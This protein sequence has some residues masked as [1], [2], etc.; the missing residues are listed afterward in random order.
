MNLPEVLDRCRQS[1]H[2]PDFSDAIRWKEEHPGSKAVGCFPVYT[3]AEIIHACGM[4]PV[5]IMGAGALGAAIL[6]GWRL[7]KT[8][9]AA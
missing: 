4:L 2:D 6:S 3:P 8:R 7:E 1:C 9:R 5:G